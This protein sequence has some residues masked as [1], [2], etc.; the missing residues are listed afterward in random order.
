MGTQRDIADSGSEYVSVTEA[1]RILGV[2]RRT[3]LRAVKA[4]R[5]PHRRFGPRGWIRVLRS[6]LTTE[7]T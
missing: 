6:A 5:L 1:A 4:K 3:V 7:A 2:H